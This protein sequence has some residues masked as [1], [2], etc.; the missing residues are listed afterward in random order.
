MVRWPNFR[1]NFSIG[2]LALLAVSFTMLRVAT[3][4][5]KPQVHDLRS[6]GATLSADVAALSPQN[7]VDRCYHQNRSLP[8]T[9]KGAC[10]RIPDNE[11]FAYLPAVRVVR[12]L[13]KRRS[14]E[15]PGLC[16]T[17]SLCSTPHTKNETT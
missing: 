1:A 13:S 3:E 7:R 17:C 8:L 16:S 5:Q 9:I 12:L 11:S 10:F 4:F 15:Q 6:P 2:L 14:G